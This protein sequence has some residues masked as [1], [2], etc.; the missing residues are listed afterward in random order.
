MEKEQPGLGI[1]ARGSGPDLELANWG[2]DRDPALA[3]IR[4]PRAAGA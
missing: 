1:V 2:A 3:H 4:E